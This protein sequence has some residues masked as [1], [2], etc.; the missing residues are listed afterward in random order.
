MNIWLAHH[1]FSLLFSFTWYSCLLVVGSDDGVC[2]GYQDQPDTGFRSVGCRS[3][4]VRKKFNVLSIIFTE[5]LKFTV[6]PLWDKNDF[7]STKWMW[8]GCYLPQ[9]GSL[10]RWIIPWADS[11]SW[12]LP[13]WS[14]KSSYVQLFCTADGSAL[15]N[16]VLGWSYEAFLFRKIVSL[17]FWLPIHC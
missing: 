7:L 2:P 1:Q 12:F 9:V 11:I 4:K 14:C 8:L 5:I 3:S 10:C 15:T 13:C 17:D 6:F 16:I